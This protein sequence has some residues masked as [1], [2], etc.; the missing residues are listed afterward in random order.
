[1]H[2]SLEGYLET[3]RLLVLV[4]QFHCSLLE[5]GLWVTCSG[6]FHLRTLKHHVVYWPAIGLQTK[7][8]SG[9]L[10]GWLSS[11]VTLEECYSVIESETRP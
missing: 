11:T 6:R 1:M 2:P 4:T 9:D 8:Q 3:D 5:S 7:T 10:K